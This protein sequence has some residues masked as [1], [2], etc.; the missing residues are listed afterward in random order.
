MCAKIPYDSR[1]QA[2]H[3]ARVFAHSGKQ[4][5]PYRCRVCGAWHLHTCRSRGKRAQ[6]W[7]E[8]ESRAALKQATRRII[9]R[10]EDEG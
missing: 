6:W 3:F 7:Q 10:G 4:Q 9:E 1:A 5:R 8:R 2:Q